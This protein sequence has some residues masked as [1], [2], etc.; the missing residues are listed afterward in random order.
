M[1]HLP[2]TV[3]S[4]RS[5]SCFT[6]IIQKDTLVHINVGLKHTKVVHFILNPLSDLIEYL[7]FYPI[8]G[9]ILVANN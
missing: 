5:M 9:P 1:Y 2:Y 6:S 8:E 4:R 7:V 3:T